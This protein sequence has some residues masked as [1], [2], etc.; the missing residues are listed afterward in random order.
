M[1]G[2]ELVCSSSEYGSL[3]ELSDNRIKILENVKEIILLVGKQL[4]PDQGVCFVMLILL[5]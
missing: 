3:V 1:L 5:I 4:L 2:F